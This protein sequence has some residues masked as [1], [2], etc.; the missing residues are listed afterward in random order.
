MAT[1]ILE[2]HANIPSV[3][4]RLA[5]ACH[6]EALRLCMLPVMH[7]LHS[8][9]K[10]LAGASPCHHHMYQ[11]VCLVQTSTEVASHLHT[12]LDDLSIYMDG[13]GIKRNT[14][15]TA[16]AWPLDERHTMHLQHC[17]GKLTSHTVFEVELIGILLGIHIIWDVAHQS[18]P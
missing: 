5:N 1:N 2:L 14:G 4:L 6:C 13:M 17:L 9:V 11:T 10:H 3:Q 12:H 18:T 15:A 16:V 8:P 7:P